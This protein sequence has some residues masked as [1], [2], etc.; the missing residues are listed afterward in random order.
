[1]FKIDI[2]DI[3]KYWGTVGACQNVMSG[4][5]ICE[6]VEKWFKIK[7]RKLKVHEQ[8]LKTG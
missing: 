1:M 3:L 2:I 7:T 5:E 8:F 4:K 6:Q